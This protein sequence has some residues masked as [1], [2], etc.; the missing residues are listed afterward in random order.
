MFTRWPSARIPLVR[1]DAAADDDA[2]G[3]RIATGEAADA[4]RS[5]G[6][7]AVKRNTSAVDPVRP[8]LKK[9]WAEGKVVSG[10]VDGQG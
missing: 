8:K 4:A 2:L 7:Q 5:T 9:A 10:G 3:E 6:V 1:D